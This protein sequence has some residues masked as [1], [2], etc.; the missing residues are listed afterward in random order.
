M[1]TRD[2]LFN[3]HLIV[4][5]EKNGYRFSIDAL[6]LAGLTRVKGAE[7][8]VDL[9]TGS[10][11]VL[12]IL[13]FRGTTATLVG[14]EIQ[15]ELAELARRN[16][17]EN[18]FAE[19]VRIVEMDYRRMSGAF[20]PGSFDLAVAN[21]PYRRLDSGRINPGAQRA[22]ARHELRGSI[23]DVFAAAAFLLRQGGRLAVIYPATR[24]E[25]LFEAARRHGFSPKELT[26]VYSD[27]TGPARLV[28]V[29]C[30]KAGGEE[31]SVASPF[32][33]RDTDG[34][35]TSAMKAMFE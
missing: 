25:S 19:V 35:Y 33:I 10:G 29:E 8:I 13:A 18:G 34:A 20:E 15:P 31:L 24:L 4:F 11:V 23:A 32:F 16:V 27:A 1:L 12:L 6:L 3:G 17:L 14:V 21:P 2:S 22:V 7:R 28:H 30:R 5:Q 26:P 9:G